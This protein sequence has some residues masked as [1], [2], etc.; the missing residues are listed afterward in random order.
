[1]PKYPLTGGELDGAR[2]DALLTFPAQIAQ[3]LT[4]LRVGPRTEA[5][6]K[7]V[8]LLQGNGPRGS[9]ATLYFDRESGLLV[10]TIRHTP[11]QIGK[12]PTQVDYEEY[13]DVAGITFPHKWTFTW[14]DGRD[15][16]EFSNVQFSLPI[17]P[18][19]FGEPV[20]PASR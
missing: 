3:S 5:Q 6:G 8:Y 11:S 13:R 19:K 14:L 20:L 15:T 16:F 2:L 12:V 9:L 4:G 18:A 7:S 10:R 17:D 1:M